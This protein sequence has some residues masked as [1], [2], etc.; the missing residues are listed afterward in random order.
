[1]MISVFLTYVLFIV[2]K[3]YIVIQQ[4]P[5]VVMVGSTIVYLLRIFFIKKAIKCFFGKVL[6]VDKLE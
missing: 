5:P 1:M 6:F 2:V 3:I 4:R